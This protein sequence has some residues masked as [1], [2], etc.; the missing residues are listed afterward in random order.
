M[1][2]IFLSLIIPAY[3]EESRI[4]GSLDKALEYFSRQ[5]YSWEIIVVDDGSTDQT[6]RIIENYNAKNPNITLIKQVNIGKGSAVRNGMLAAHG[7]YRV[8]TDADFSTPIYELEKVLPIL[9]AGTDICIGSRSIDRS[10]VKEH[11]PFY[12]EWMGKTFNKFVQLLVFKGIVDTQCG[13]KGF[14]ASAAER[15]FSQAKING[16]SF[17]VEVLFL[18]KLGKMTIKEV[19]IEWYNDERSKVNPISDSTRMFLELIK[20]RRLH[21]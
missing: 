17:D 19:P 4:S 5:D 16:F 12:R 7:K 18:A 9:S 2:S 10:M 11:Q 6:A 1:E 20:I 13:F 15:I 8:F 21:K 3:N 14:T